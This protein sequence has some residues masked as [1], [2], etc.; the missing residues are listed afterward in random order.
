M[1]EKT[2]ASAIAKAMGLSSAHE[3]L[4]K[5]WDDEGKAGQGACLGDEVRRVAELRSAGRVSFDGCR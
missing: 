5:Q 4:L 1:K 3:G 2:L